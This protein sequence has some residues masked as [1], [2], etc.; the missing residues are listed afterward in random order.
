[1]KTAGIWKVT[2]TQD[3]ETTWNAPTGHTYTTR[4]EPYET[5]AA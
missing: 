4:A 5:A 1:M 3:G 2:R